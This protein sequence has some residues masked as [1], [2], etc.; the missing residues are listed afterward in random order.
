MSPHHGNEIISYDG[1]VGA[2]IQYTLRLDRKQAEKVADIAASIARAARELGFQRVD[3]PLHL[4]GTAC[5]VDRQ[6]DPG[7]AWVLVEAQRQLDTNERLVPE[8][9]HVVQ[10]LPGDGCDSA[11]LGLARYV[12]SSDWSWKGTCKLHPHAADAD[13]VVKSHVALCELL[14]QVKTLGVTVDV[15]DDA[16]YWTGRDRAALA[17]RV[18]ESRTAQAADLEKLAANS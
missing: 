4:I 7:L 2:F 8:E 14:D 17:E 16:G 11:N 12:D 9:L 15:V 1:A 5:D 13:A 10:T 6:P 18:S 3:E